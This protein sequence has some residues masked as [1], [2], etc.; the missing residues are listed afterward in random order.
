M[1]SLRTSRNR[2]VRT[3]LASHVWRTT[4][5][6]PVRCIFSSRPHQKR[7]CCTLSQ[8]CVLSLCRREQSI[9]SQ[10]AL[11]VLP[12]FIIGQPAVCLANL[13]S[14]TACFSGICLILPLPNPS[15]FPSLVYACDR[16]IAQFVMEDFQQCV[17]C[18]YL[19]RSSFDPSHVVCSLFRTINCR[20]LSPGSRRSSSAIIFLPTFH[21]VVVDHRFSGDGSLSRSCSNTS[22]FTKPASQVYT[23]GR[24]LTTSMIT[25]IL[26][27]LRCFRMNADLIA[28]P[29]FT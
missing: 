1:N 28:V 3:I 8:H 9:V 6:Y 21:C 17:H 15:A 19:P 24:C 14:L 25:L 23:P 11:L 12:E 4:R 7:P 27:P 20:N 10:S 29:N 26:W 2:N 22:S 5:S 13:M 18:H 16:T